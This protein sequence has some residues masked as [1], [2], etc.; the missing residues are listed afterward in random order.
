MLIWPSSPLNSRSNLWLIHQYNN[1][2]TSIL[3]CKPFCSDTTGGHNLRE[4]HRNKIYTHVSICKA[5]C[6]MSAGR[7]REGKEFLVVMSGSQQGS[8][9]PHQHKWTPEALLPQLLRILHDLFVLTN[10]PWLREV[11]RMWGHNKPANFYRFWRQLLYRQSLKAG[12]FLPGNSTDSPSGDKQAA[13]SHC[14]IDLA[15]GKGER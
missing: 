7:V 14:G 5:Q 15:E 1:F 11:W 13:D 12:C 2:W 4:Y 9:K 6:N 3:L 8:D 10:S